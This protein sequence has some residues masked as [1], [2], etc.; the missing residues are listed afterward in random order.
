MRARGIRFA[1]AALVGLGSLFA[2][3]YSLGAQVEDTQFSALTAA[4]QIAPL[5][6]GV[7]PPGTPLPPEQPA[8]TPAL[9]KNVEKQVWRDPLSPR[10]VNLLFADAVRTEKP[11]EIVDRLADLLAQLSWRYTPAQQNLI[12]RA[13]VAGDAEDVMD[14]VDALLRRQRQPALAYTALAAM[15]AIPEV[16]ETIVQKLAVQ[17]AWRAGY[18]TVISPQSQPALLDARARTLAALLRTRGG[19]TREEMAPSLIALTASGRVEAAHRLWSMKNGER[20]GGENL[21][22]DPDFKDAFAHAGGAE[23]GIPFEW[24][25]GRDLGYAA[26]A[27]ADGVAINWDRRGV[28]IF[29]T[30]TLPLQSGRSYA[31]LLQGEADSASLTQLLSPA[32]LCGA[33]AVRFVPVVGEGEQNTASYRTGPLPDDCETGVLAINGAVDSGA[34]PV[35][36]RLERV[37]LSRAN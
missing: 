10:M 22:Y 6:E 33:E 4:A 25:L 1:A 16:E 15:E 7:L 37:V 12:L 3:A 26:Y 17:P 21:V 32:L 31:L 36:I 20:S 27:A 24:R 30:Q 19:M 9:R 5:P 18:L 29:L 23:L 28:P 34:G 13:L 2:S 11:A 14:R 35:N 8:L